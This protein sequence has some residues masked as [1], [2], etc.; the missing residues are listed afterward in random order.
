MTFMTKKA[1]AGGFSLIELMIVVVITAV[2]AG[3]AY[4]TYQQYTTQARRSDAQSALTQTANRLEK[5]FTYCNSYPTSATPLT[6]AWPATCP[7]NAATLAAAGL[8]LPGP[9]PVLSPDRHYAITMVVDTSGPTCAVGVGS[10]CNPLP[11]GLTL[12][13]CQA[14]CGYTLVADPTVAGT[15]GRQAT[16]GRFRL[17]SRGVKEWDRNNDTDY[18]DTGENRWTK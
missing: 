7:T 2:L 18:A 14:R 10:P 1:R 6:S 12:A 3:I 11:A 5:F 4:P 13:Q 9:L 17:D 16:D 15:S 8:G